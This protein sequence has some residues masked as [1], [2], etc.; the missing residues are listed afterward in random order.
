MLTL[1][2]VEQVAGDAEAVAAGD[3]SSVPERVL[4]SARGAPEGLVAA[5]QRMYATKRSFQVRKHDSTVS[6]LLRTVVEA[7]DR[8][9][10]R[11][12]AR[13]VRVPIDPDTLQRVV[14]YM[15]MRKGSDMPVVYKPISDAVLE[16]NFCKDG[17]TVPRDMADF[18]RG[19]ESGSFARVKRLMAAANWLDIPGLFSLCCAYAASVV[20]GRPRAEIAARLAT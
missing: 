5:V 1:T 9:Q 16:N 20:R 4:A 7:D 3:M 13:V 6:G 19:V 8:D 10:D 17:N 11:G 14:E 18:I 15:E 12:H 2:S